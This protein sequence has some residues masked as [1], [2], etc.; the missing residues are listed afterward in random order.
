MQEKRRGG[1]EVK[2]DLAI[3]EDEVTDLKFFYLDVDSGKLMV[4]GKEI[5]N[6][7]AFSFR[8]TNGKYGLDI[9]H[10]VKYAATVP[11]CIGKEVS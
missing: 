5:N 2:K 10:D 4:N 7:T 8:F 9:T 6:V 1:E 11:L 3:H